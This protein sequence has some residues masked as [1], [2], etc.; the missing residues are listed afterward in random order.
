M[1]AVVPYARGNCADTRQP[2]FHL[3]SIAA[4]V[5]RAARSASRGKRKYIFLLSARALTR[6]IRAIQHPPGLERDTYRADS[7]P[8]RSRFNSLLSNRLT[9]H[10]R[11]KRK[12]I[13]ICKTEGRRVRMRAFPLIAEKKRVL[14]ARAPPGGNKHIEFIALSA[15]REKIFSFNVRI[16]RC[17]PF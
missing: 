3:S 17:V 7:M 4:L 5:P 9:F 12:E 2:R 15:A 8:H 11:R 1:D 16:A 6:A 10:P 13:Y 14:R